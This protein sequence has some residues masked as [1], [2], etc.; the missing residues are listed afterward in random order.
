M[1]L[2]AIA[3]PVLPPSQMIAGEMTPDEGT[4]TVGETVKVCT[5][6]SIVHACREQHAK[7]SEICIALVVVQSVVFFFEVLC[8]CLLIL[9]S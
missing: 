5:A 7:L 9:L 3:A 4:L 6:M 1:F 2:C 8:A